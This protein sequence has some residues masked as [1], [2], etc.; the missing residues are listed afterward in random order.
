MKNKTIRTKTMG[1]STRSL[2]MNKWQMMLAAGLLVFAASCVADTSADNKMSDN[3]QV[4]IKGMI[5]PAT[6]G[7]GFRLKT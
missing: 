4:L 7:H 2:L 6:F 5:L 3:V 1:T